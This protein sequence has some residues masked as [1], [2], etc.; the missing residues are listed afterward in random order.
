MNDFKLTYEFDSYRVDVANRLVFHHDD[1]LPLTPKAVEILVALIAHRGE[2]MSKNDLMSI[3]WPDTVVED[4]NLAQNIY[5]LRKTLDEG[6]NGRR[7]VETV[8]RRGY[9]FVGDVH[10]TRNGSRQV[11]HDQAWTAG[12]DTSAELPYGAASQDQTEFTNPELPSNRIQTYALF[13][14][15]G[16]LL[17]GLLITLLAFNARNARST[18]L[19][20]SPAELSYIKGRQFWNKQTTPAL[21]EAIQYFNESLRRDQNYAPAYAGLADAYI[22]LSERYDMGHHDKDALAKAMAAA[23]QAVRL[24]ERRAE[25]HAALAI[26]MQQSDWDWKTAETE[27]K[28]AIELDP[29]YAYAHQRYACLLAALGR[30]A[31][32]KAEITA[33]LKLDPSS[34]SINADA[35]QILWFG[36][37]YQASITQ[38]RN[39]I[40]LDPSQP[41]AASLHR[42]L[43]LI[44]EERSM[45]EQAVAEFI[46]TLRLQ[47]GS[48]EKISA[49]RQAYDSGGV[50]GYWLKWLQFRE[51][52][53]KLGGINPLNV[54]QVYALV[55]DMDNAFEQLQKACDDHSLPVAAL[56]FGPTFEK[57]RSDQR[58]SAILKRVKLN[59]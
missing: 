43:G 31:E 50:K 52:R 13:T 42:W 41:M 20:S 30:S 26:V 28:R 9:R 10:E 49:L 32:A 39:A 24:D 4:G 14:A 16:L 3:V 29:D 5:L 33:A 2:I 1:A 21:E 23:R 44:Y 35:A 36:G 18:S 12:E 53:I 57:L 55:G 34:P 11:G 22:S 40:E 25:G 45:H 54:A 17:V 51:Q 37:D 47:N 59:S 58:Y 8:A 6:S 15:V 19:A 46:E 56:R 38:F 48:P 27:F 7:Y